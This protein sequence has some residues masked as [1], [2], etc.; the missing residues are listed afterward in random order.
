MRKNLNA[1]YCVIDDKYRFYCKKQTVLSKLP[2]VLRKR[3]NKFFLLT[4]DWREWGRN[5]GNKVVCLVALSIKLYVQAPFFQFN[6]FRMRANKK[7]A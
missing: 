1:N 7:N 3:E 5:L 6:S 4:I 2:E